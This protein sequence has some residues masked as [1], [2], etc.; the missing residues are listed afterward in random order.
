MGLD[1]EK[2]KEWCETGYYEGVK[3]RFL[4]KIRTIEEARN[5]GIKEIFVVQGK[6]RSNLFVPKDIW[7]KKKEN[8]NRLG[9]SYKKLVFKSKKRKVKK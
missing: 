9:E 5:I 6:F 2:L 4:R 1:E 8:L 7:N 3:L